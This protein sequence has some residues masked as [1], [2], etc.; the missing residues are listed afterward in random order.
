M[1]SSETPYR[2]P[3]DPDVETLI[4]SSSFTVLRREVGPFSGSLP[5][6]LYKFKFLRGASS[7]EQLVEIPGGAAQPVTVAPRADDLA[8]DTAVPTARSKRAVPRQVSAAR[9]MSQQ[10]QAKR[11]AGGSSIYVFVRND[12]EAPPRDP[13][14]GF[15]LH[16][17]DDSLVADLGKEAVRDDAH[18]PSCAAFNIDVEPGPY[19]L[20]FHDGEEALEQMVIASRHWQTQVFLIH[21]RAAEGETAHP[22]ANA[23]VL[24][25]RGGFN[26][27]D[28]MMH[29]ADAA[30]VAL[31]LGR[32]RM[33]RELVSRLLGEKFDNPML[34]IYAAH[35]VAAGGKSE[36][37]P[38]LLEVLESMVPGHPDVVA[39]RLD[40]A[41]GVEIET[42]PML[43]SSWNR[44]VAA[45]LDGKVALCAG[46]LASRLPPSV[47]T[48]T[49]W[50]I[51]S[52]GELLPAEAT[53]HRDIGADL[54]EIARMA[55]AEAEEWMR[56]KLGE[57]WRLSEWEEAVYSY[58]QRRASHQRSDTGLE[59]MLPRLD[60]RGIARAFGTTVGHVQ[61]TVAG[62]AA[63]LKN[64]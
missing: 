20:R 38:R 8:L 58:L 34:G 12:A 44:I 64:R 46:S 28:E 61:A 29:L 9:E 15:T 63:K 59:S 33:P 37:L 60:E 21:R 49:P 47:L 10:T 26:P 27:D 48:G 62:L 4:I 22:L 36:M 1:S 5:P 6:G 42:P 35:A 56:K 57:G 23:S 52:A 31:G 24:M 14:A 51:W 25:C 45:S 30:R 50:L 55:G 53:A 39:L 2:V 43:R 40:S 16:A 7:A 17:L 3:V 11:G 13:A 54:D 32:V 18:Q 41:E 19:R